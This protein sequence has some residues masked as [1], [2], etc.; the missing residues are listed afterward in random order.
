MVPMQ[1]TGHGKLRPATPACVGPLLAGPSLAGTFQTGCGPHAHQGIAVKHFVGGD[2]IVPVQ[3]ALGYR[4]AKRR[5][6]AL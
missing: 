3:Y 6:P 5:C 4:Q 1:G 2:Q